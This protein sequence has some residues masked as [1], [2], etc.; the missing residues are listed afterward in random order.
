MPPRP[1]RETKRTR[2][3]QLMKQGKEGRQQI[4][5]K[6]QEY[7]KRMPEI[8]AGFLDH[9]ESVRGAAKAL[10]IPQTTLAQFVKREKWIEEIDR[11]RA[12]RSMAEAEG[13]AIGKP[14]EEA[15]EETPVPAGYLET[16]LRV[17]TPIKGRIISMH[18]QDFIP[19]SVIQFSRDD[20]EKVHLGDVEPLYD[21]SQEMP[22][23]GTKEDST[24]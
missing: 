2:G 15:R 10:G 18:L 4:Q 20:L 9:G 3:N 1:P 5:K 11:Q 19:T 12:L 6:A 22:A 13:I 17:L 24:L 21:I 23:P 14:V 16:F 8:V 7:L